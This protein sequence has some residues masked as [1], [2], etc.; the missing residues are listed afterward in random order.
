MR[1]IALAYK[2]TQRA[3]CTAILAIPLTPA[4]LSTY[5]AAFYAK[6]RPF[7]FNNYQTAPPDNLVINCR[8]LS[9]RALLGSKNTTCLMD[10]QPVSNISQTTNYYHRKQNFD[11]DCQAPVVGAFR[12]LIRRVPTRAACA[13]EINFARCP[14][15]TCDA[16]C[17]GWRGLVSLDL[18]GGRI[19]MQ[20]P[21]RY[22]AHTIPRSSI[23]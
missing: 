20:Y 4:A 1:R 6:C 2:H 18:A 17:R 14:R 21:A 10:R 22:V 19:A 12:G 11:T 3:D 13:P 8:L 7:L 9:G 23:I 5:A 16:H 15:S